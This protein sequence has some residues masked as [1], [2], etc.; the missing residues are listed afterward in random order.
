M[1]KK[2]LIEFLK[3]NLKISVDTE[4]KW[5]NRTQLEVAINLIVDG[6][7]I[8]IDRDFVMLD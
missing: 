2:E 3:N 6:E 5:G 7:E 4:E 8:E 1:D